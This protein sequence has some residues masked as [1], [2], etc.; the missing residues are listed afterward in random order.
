M[1]LHYCLYLLLSFPSL[2]CLP[3]TSEQGRTFYIPLFMLFNFRQSFCRKL[4][5][6]CFKK[7]WQT[8]QKHKDQP[9]YLFVGGFDRK[10]YTTFTSYSQECLMVIII[11]PSL[12]ASSL[13]EEVLKEAKC[14]VISILLKQKCCIYNTRRFSYKYYQR[15]TTSTLKITQNYVKYMINSEGYCTVVVNGS[16]VVRHVQLKGHLPAL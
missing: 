9:I 13:L 7:C 15:Q 14:N 8:L 10:T 12:A 2:N 6:S 5:S 1:P 3:F 16:S 4:M 11:P